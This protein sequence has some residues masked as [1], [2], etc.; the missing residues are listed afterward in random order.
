MFL[1][2]EEDVV[3]VWALRTQTFLFNIAE[4]E[5]MDTANDRI[6]AGFY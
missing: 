3:C 6:K 5:K 1:W 4:A 2:D